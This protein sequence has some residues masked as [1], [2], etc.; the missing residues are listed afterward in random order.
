MAQH[1]RCPSDA[2][3]DR[4]HELCKNRSLPAE[5]PRQRTSAHVWH[6]AHS[7]AVLCV[8]E[9]NVATT[10]PSR[11]QSRPECVRPAAILRDG[12]CIFYSEGSLSMRPPMQIESRLDISRTPLFPHM[13]IGIIA[14]NSCTCSW[15]RGVTIPV[16]ET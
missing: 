3:Y 5:D 10:S 15:T 7:R 2:V 12:V 4:R 16:A 11:N 14:V 6:L 8:K 13:R 1:R 9:D